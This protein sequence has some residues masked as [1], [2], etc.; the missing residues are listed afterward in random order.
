MQDGSHDTRA[1]VPRLGEN[2][3]LTRVQTASVKPA[4]NWAV[5]VQGSVSRT[6]IPRQSR[7]KP[8]VNQELSHFQKRYVVRFYFLKTQASNQE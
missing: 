2:E 8:R 1:Y 7:Q 4:I 6:P 3:R 5:K